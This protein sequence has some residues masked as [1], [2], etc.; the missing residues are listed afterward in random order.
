MFAPTIDPSRADKLRDLTVEL[1]CY[2][3]FDA[4][5][6]VGISEVLMF[7]GDPEHAAWHTKE[8]H[9]RE[10][11]VKSSSVAAQVR[12]LLVD[13]KAYKWRPLHR[14]VFK[15]NGIPWWPVYTPEFFDEM[16]PAFVFMCFR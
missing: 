10:C 12:R 4:S 2:L 7:E 13:D 3:S 1:M 5:V 8:A 15:N 6:T 16:C 9:E 11:R 14:T